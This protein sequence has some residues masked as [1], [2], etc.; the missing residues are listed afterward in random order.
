MYGLFDIEQ[1][2]TV[3]AHAA[4]D[5]ALANLLQRDTV[6]WERIF[7]DSESLPGF[8]Q[9][10][11]VGKDHASFASMLF[12]CAPCKV[13]PRSLKPTQFFIYYVP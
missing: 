9:L 2:V 13:L 7:Q 11:R 3:L 8:G 10:R 12:G 1:A 5:S 6:Y 4:P